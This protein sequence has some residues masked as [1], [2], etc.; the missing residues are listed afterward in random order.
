MVRSLFVRKFTILPGD[1]I[2]PCYPETFPGLC[3]LRNC[4]QVSFK[5]RLGTS[6]FLPFSESCKYMS[7][8]AYEH[9]DSPT[10]GGNVVYRSGTAMNNPLTGI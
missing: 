5:I 7:D 6:D 8:E 9:F 1:R 2:R 10:V 4:D 3:F